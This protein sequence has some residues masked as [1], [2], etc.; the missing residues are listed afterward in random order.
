MEIIVDY[1]H[2]VETA[3]AMCKT[4]EHADTV[5]LS[6]VKKEI[7]RCETILQTALFH[8]IIFQKCTKYEYHLKIR[9]K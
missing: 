4:K 2:H 1:V 8:K 5:L 3:S 7:I 9:L 6:D